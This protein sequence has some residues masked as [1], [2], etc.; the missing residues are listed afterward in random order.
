MIPNITFTFTGLV[1]VKNE[2]GKNF[3]IS[4]TDPLFLNG[5]LKSI[6]CGTNN[7]MHE[8]SLYKIWI[9]KYGKEEADIRTKKLSKIQS[10]NTKGEN[11]PMF[12]KSL[13]DVWLKNKGKIIADNLLKEY[14]EKMSNIMKGENNSMFG[15]SVYDV[16]VQKYGIE[17]ANI[18]MKKSYKPLSEERK[19]KTSKTLKGNVMWIYNETLNKSMYIKKELFFEFKVQGWIQGRCKKNS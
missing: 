9:E 15:K 12:E 1:I 6:I 11:N 10:E 3:V 16:W 17:E 2:N 18:K 7:G 5:T 4:N 19:N 8:K 13:Y 14:K